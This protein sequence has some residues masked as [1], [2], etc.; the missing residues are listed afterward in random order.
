MKSIKK[1]IRKVLADFKIKRGFRYD[2][3]YYK[4]YNYSSVFSKKSIDAELFRVTHTIEKGLSLSCPRKGFGLKKIEY[5]FSL[6]NLY[7]EKSFDVADVAF[8]N[9]VDVLCKYAG[10]QKDLGFEDDDLYKKIDSLQKYNNKSLV[11]G[12]IVLKR[13]DLMSKSK[14]GYEE[15][16]LSRHSC[17]QFSGEAVSLEKVKQ[18]ISLASHCPSECNRQP[19][20]AYVTDSKESFEYLSKYIAGNRGFEREVNRY[21]VISSEINCYHDMYERNQLYIDGGI[22]LH[23]VVEAL[24][25][26]DIATC[27]LQ[28]GEYPVKDKELKS[29][30]KIP[31][32]EKIIAFIAIGNY[33]DIFPVSISNRKSVDSMLHII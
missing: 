5:L 3:K 12:T 33:K 32:N 11:A 20:H 14:S 31:N 21:L 6:I 26:F 29:G 22:F 10:L 24:H 30:L 25:Y 17:R 1:I 2:E 28:N 16:V 27:I 23:A 15:F 18:A 7:V 13:V 8:Q 9:A 19:C 4:K